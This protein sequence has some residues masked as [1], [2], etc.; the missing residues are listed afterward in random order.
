[1][2]ISPLDK[3]IEICENSQTELAKRIGTGQ[4]TVGA[5]VNRFNKRVGDGFVLKVAQATNYQ[6]TPHQLR[7]DLYPHPHDG[8]PEHLRSA[9]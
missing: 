5:W 4:A 2:I 3:A 9:A 1:M 7:P 6:V 8:L